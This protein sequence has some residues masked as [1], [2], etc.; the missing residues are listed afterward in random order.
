MDQQ[1]REI[2]TTTLPH[3]T[4]QIRRNV[5]FSCIAN[6]SR[7]IRAFR[8]PLLPAPLPIGLSSVPA[9]PGNKSRFQNGTLDRQ[10]TGLQ[11]QIFD[12]RPLGR[13]PPW[14]GA[15]IPRRVHRF[16]HLS[17]TPPGQGTVPTGDSSC[18]RLRRRPFFCA[19]IRRPG[20]IPWGQTPV[21][22]GQMSR[23]PDP[24]SQPAET[25]HV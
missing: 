25:G 14:P 16:R 18:L 3:C 23:F 13:E 1:G 9:P 4:C 15:K 11:G 2:P 8:T 24:A 19:H 22:G 12:S 21:N 10:E 5:T 20:L 7:R 17:P 6:S